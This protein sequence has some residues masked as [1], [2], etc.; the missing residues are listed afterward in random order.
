MRIW[1]FAK[2]LDV[3]AEAAKALLDCNHGAEPG[4]EDSGHRNA[5]CSEQAARWHGGGG[6]CGGAVAG[7]SFGTC[8]RCGWTGFQCGFERGTAGGTV[9][10]G[11]RRRQ[12]ET[13]TW[14]GP[15]QRCAL[16][17]VCSC[18]W[19]AGFADY[20]SAL[21]IFCAGVWGEVVADVPGSGMAGSS[22]GA[23]R[24]LRGS[25]PVVR[26]KLVLA[27]EPEGASGLKEKRLAY[28]GEF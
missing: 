19:T 27:G 26:G 10:G 21:W 13:G 23:L 5:R 25:V 2:A 11:C 24:G 1:R 15:I 22:S 14:G 28:N 16:E 20:G 4:R 7:C 18:D 6:C 9:T 17:A 3:R 8:R 12:P